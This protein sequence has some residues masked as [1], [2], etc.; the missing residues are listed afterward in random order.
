MSIVR[1]S[2]LKAKPGEWII[3]SGWHQEKWN[4]VPSSV[5]D[6][7]PADDALSKV[8]PDNPVLLTHASGHALIANAKAR[9]LA[10]VTRATEDPKGGK[11]LRDPKGN[12]TG[13]F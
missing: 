1:E 2:A 8:T 10:G 9:E 12:P 11:I 6:G 4:R 3:G 7:Y 5:I 13:V